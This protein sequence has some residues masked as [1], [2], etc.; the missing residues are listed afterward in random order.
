VARSAL[1][2]TGQRLVRPGVVVPRHLDLMTPTLQALRQLGGSATIAELVDKVIDILKPSSEILEHP[3]GDGRNT[4]L[5]YQLAWARTYL[6]KY[7]LLTNSAHGVW[8]LTPK[9]SGITVVDTDAVIKVL[10]ADRQPRKQRGR[11]HARVDAGGVAASPV[12]Q[13]DSW[14]DRLLTA[15]LA[16]KPAAFER[17]SQR[18]L[19][20]SGF[21]EVE[22]TGRSGDGGIDGHGIIRVARLI[23]FPVLFQCKRY[24]GN[25][26][27]SAVR[28]FR[29]AM[30]GRADKGLIITT[31]G[32]TREARAEATRD[33]APPIDLI[34][35]EMLA[36]KLKELQLGVTTRLVEEVDVEEDWF[37]S[38]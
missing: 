24:S 32:F 10:R 3:H 27:P 18:L 36:D 31:G 20:E 23:S 14:R 38:L 1:E 21:I 29:G 16:M 28:D 33:G 7:G 13:E 12:A 30:M 8:A 9:A 2:A 11:R 34:D 25:A 37:A 6:K 19:R 4:E 5:E 17:L 22:V 35:G 15:L 26:G